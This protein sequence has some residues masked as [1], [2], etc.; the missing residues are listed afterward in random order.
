ML[1]L[2]DGGGAKEGLKDWINVELIS[3][4]MFDV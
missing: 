4:L 2:K 1:R 3:S